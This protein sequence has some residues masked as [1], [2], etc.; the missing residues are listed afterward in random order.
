MS[1]WDEAGPERPSLYEKIATALAAEEVLET[2][3]CS[4]PKDRDVVLA[5]INREIHDWEKP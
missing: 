3:C 2:A 4:C 5:V 1:A